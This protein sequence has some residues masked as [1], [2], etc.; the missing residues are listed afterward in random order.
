MARSSN[1]FRYFVLLLTRLTFNTSIM[2][3]RVTTTIS[4]TKCLLSS[5]FEFVKPRAANTSKAQRI[6]QVGIF[7]GLFIF[8]IAALNDYVIVASIIVIAI[9]NSINCAAL[10]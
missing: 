4:Y 1:E 3:N 8:V 6:M 5:V 2:I 9:R 10:F 7:N